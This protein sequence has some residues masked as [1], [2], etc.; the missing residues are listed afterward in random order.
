V[1]GF[2]PETIFEKIHDKKTA[3]RERE[4]EIAI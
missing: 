3:E 1:I 4:K 2:N